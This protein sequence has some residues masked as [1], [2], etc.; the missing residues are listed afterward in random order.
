MITIIVVFVGTFC[1]ILQ[2]CKVDIKPEHFCFSV[3][4]CRL[5]W[6]STLICRNHKVTLFHLS[7]QSTF[8]IRFP[9]L[10]DS[11]AFFFFL[12]LKV[13]CLSLTGLCDFAVQALAANGADLNEKDNR[14]NK[15]QL[16]VWPRGWLITIEQTTRSHNFV[17]FSDHLL[18][19]LI[20]HLTGCTAAHLAA[21]HGNSYCLQSILR[22]GVVS[23]I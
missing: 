8:M 12:L 7:I 19:L 10:V 13:I 20:I 1:S 14:G 18:S 21:A 16:K 15:L 17:T 3:A 6:L 11:M 2:V 9:R 23:Y 22:H 5:K 4:D